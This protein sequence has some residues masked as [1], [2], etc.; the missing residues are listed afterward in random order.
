M[1]EKT[2]STLPDE[3]IT[4]QKEMDSRESLKA[5]AW[6]TVSRVILK[7]ATMLLT[8]LYARLM[9][10]A[11]Y[12]F[13]ATIGTWFSIV[14]TVATGHVG[15]GLTR[16]KY[17][18][19]GKL[20]E[21]ISS[22][23]FLG[24]MITLFFYG[25]VMIFSDFFCNLFGCRIE[26]F[27]I[28]FGSLLISPALGYQQG[29][30][31]LENKYRLVVFITI[32]SWILSSAGNLL[33]LVSEPFRQAVM[34]TE[35]S[36]RILAMY[37]GS[38]FPSFVV[39]LV[40]YAVLICR[41]RVL[42]NFKYWRYALSM[43]VP[44]IPHILAGYILNHS[45]RIMITDICGEEFT[46]LYSITYTCSAVVSMLFNSLNEA[47]V[48]WFTDKFFFH[49]ESTIK[50]VSTIYC[51]IF[52]V[53][54]IGMLLIG[55]ELLMILGGE[56]YMPALSIMPVVMVSCY[57]QFTNAFFVNVETYEKKTIHTAIGTLISA[58]INVG[59]NALLLPLF[60]YKVA[61]YTTLIG[62]V[63]L[64]VYHYFTARRLVGA[65]KIKEL[66]PIKMIF[67]LIGSMLLLMHPMLLLYKVLALRVAIILLCVGG[68]G[69]AAYKYKDMLLELVKT[70]KKSKT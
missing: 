55:P 63:F 45:D 22:I 32:G 53:M 23:T 40:V 60:G 47:W 29:K 4:I 6:Y 37:V 2:V 68:M 21:F 19:P 48:P 41:G 70:F 9:T 27:H 30:N 42:V 11:E 56:N 33:M 13:N 50:R 57:F 54:T 31:R 64:F 59:L 17:E 65:Q 25:L 16:A 67:C 26:F 58:V 3:G 5:G 44:L 24:S 49:R 12:G 7:G 8:P 1:N 18:F 14:T 39:N 20:N 61:A 43:G 28:V 35:A 36:D 69:F 10:M 34:G 38:H 66:Y 62:F 46:A 51:L 52:F 15:A